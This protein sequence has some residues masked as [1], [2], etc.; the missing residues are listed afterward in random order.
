METKNVIISNEYLEKIKK[1]AAI[2]PEETF[3][4]VPLAYRDFE[5]ELQPI[6]IL[7]PISGEK[8]L[9][10]SDEMSGDVTIGKGLTSVKVKRGSFVV[11]VVKEGLLN[12]Q[13]FYNL[14]GKIIEYSPTSFDCLQ[15]RLIEELSEAI[16][17]RSSISEEEVLGLK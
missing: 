6:F 2:Q 3:E 4:Y 10:F 7:K 1:F 11:S 9:K 13:N 15:R 5:K 8:I 17:S 16:L 12:W 14:K